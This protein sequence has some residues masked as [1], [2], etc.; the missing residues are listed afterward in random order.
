MLSPPECNIFGAIRKI[1]EAMR[2]TAAEIKRLSEVRGAQL[3]C[4]RL[5]WGCRTLRAIRD[6]DM[7]KMQQGI[8][9]WPKLREA[10]AN[11]DILRATNET[12]DKVAEWVRAEA[13]TDL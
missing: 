1:K 10:F 9:A 12:V 4:E 3:T 11:E 2:A 13:L 6:G 5:Y 7:K 8:R